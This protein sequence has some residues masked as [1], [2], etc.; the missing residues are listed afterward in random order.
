VPENSIF[1]LTNLLEGKGYVRSREDL[2]E[3]LTLTEEGSY[4]LKNGL[5]ETRLINFLSSKGG[6]APLKELNQVLRNQEISA[7]LGWGRRSGVVIIEKHGSGFGVRQGSGKVTFSGGV[8][9]VAA[10]SNLRITARVPAGA[11]SGKIK[12][13]N[14]AGDFAESPA[15]FMVLP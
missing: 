9:A 3:I 7:A 12:V 1:P 4:C 10:W 5:P 11:T 6:S 15:D 13:V 14:D 8:A 2:G